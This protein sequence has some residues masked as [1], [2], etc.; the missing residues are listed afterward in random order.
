M[1]DGM[2]GYVMYNDKSTMSVHL[3]MTGYQE[4]DLQFPNFS[5]TISIE[6]LKHL[7]KTYT[8][9][10]TYTVNEEEGYVQH[11]RISHSNP[12]EWNAVVRRKYTFDGDT[13]ILQPL[14][15]ETANLR[16]KWLRVE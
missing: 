15:S 14:E 8:Y 3:T 12:A 10:A 1:A 11:A 5:D 6:A 2:Q 13:L 9:F 4:T 7:T 16:L